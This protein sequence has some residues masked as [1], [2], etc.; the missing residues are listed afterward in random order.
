MGYYNPIHIYGVAKFLADAKSVGVDGLIVVDLPPEH[1]DELCL[2]ARDVDIDFIRLATPTTDG[3]RLPA[4]LNN[5]SG[6]LYYVAIAGIT[7]T[8]PLP[9]PTSRK[10]GDASQRAHGAANRGWLR[11]QDSAPGRRRSRA[12]PT[13]RWSAQRWWTGSPPISTTMRALGLV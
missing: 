10:R 5:I 11:H 4:V 3:R 7:G 12:S 1:D 13:R 8:V 9:S 6:F 2:P